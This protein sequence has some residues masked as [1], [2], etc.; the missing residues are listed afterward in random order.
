MF[1]FL[2]RLKAFH[3]EKLFSRSKRTLLILN[4]LYTTLLTGIQ[5]N[6]YNSMTKSMEGRHLKL[7][8][9]ELLI[10]IMG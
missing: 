6:P 7:D 8:A 2:N 9:L 5:L 1:T 3:L 4:R 10:A